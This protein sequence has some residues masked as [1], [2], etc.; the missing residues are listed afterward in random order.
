M[1]AASVVIT[2]VADPEMLAALYRDLH[3][4]PEL[5]FQETRTAGIAAESLR[6]LGFEVT[7]GVGRTGVVGVMRRGD[8]PT[9]LVRADMDALP[10]E[11]RTGLDYAST[12]RGI[13][14]DGNVRVASLCVLGSLKEILYQLI[15]RD[16]EV[17][18]GELVE[19]LLSLHRTGLIAI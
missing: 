17:D 16:F 3:A 7:T 9:V 1:T 14:P 15:M 19:S 10:V 11:E 12:A 13:V 5:S 4:H 2:G 18:E 8:G 6:A